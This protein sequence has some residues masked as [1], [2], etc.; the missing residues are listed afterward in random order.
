MFRGRGGAPA[1]PINQ[2]DEIKIYRGKFYPVCGQGPWRG[3]YGFV[4]PDGGHKV[5]P[6]CDPLREARASVLFETLGL[7]SDVLNSK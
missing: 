1:G 2:T 5:A 7:L 3:P 4:T 6:I